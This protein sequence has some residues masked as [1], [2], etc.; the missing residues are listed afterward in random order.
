MPALLIQE[1]LERS[2]GF[3]NCAF[4]RV[5]NKYYCAAYNEGEALSF[6]SKIIQ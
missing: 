3:E 6:S 5:M 4:G 1:L 2:Q